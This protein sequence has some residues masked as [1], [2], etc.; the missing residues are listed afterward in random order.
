[1]LC[2]L[3]VVIHDWPATLLSSQSGVVSG[4]APLPAYVEE[5]VNRTI[6]LERAIL[7]AHVSHDLVVV[8]G[9]VGLPEVCARVHVHVSWRGLHRILFDYK[10]VLDPLLPPPFPSLLSV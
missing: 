7:S 8:Y 4:V 2:S 9:D 6:E 5:L 1:M 10:Y 3:V